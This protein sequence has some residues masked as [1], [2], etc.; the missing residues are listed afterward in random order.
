MTGLV[1]LQDPAPPLGGNLLLDSAA[2]LHIMKASVLDE[3]LRRLPNLWVLQLRRKQPLQRLIF[4][5]DACNRLDQT[6]AGLDRPHKPG[7]HHL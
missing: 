3:L 6:C 1:D 7:L 2:V 5:H 4:Q